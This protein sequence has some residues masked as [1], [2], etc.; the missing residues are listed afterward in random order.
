MMHDLPVEEVFARLQTSLHG[1]SEEEARRR[2]TETGPNAL[3]EE[4]PPH[5]VLIF[6]KQFTDVMILILMAAAVIAWVTGDLTD[7]LVILA[8]VV[9]N[10]IL[11]FTQEYRAERAL[12]AL[13][14][15]EIP[16]VL[17]TRDGHR[18]EIPAPELVPGDLVHLSPGVRVP[19][20]ARLVAAVHLQADESPL[21][22]ESVPVAKIREPIPSGA[23]LMERRN[24]LYMGTT[25]LAGRGDAVVAATGMETELGRIAHL[26]QTTVKGETPLQ[27]RLATLGKWLAAA[28]LAICAVIF[29]AGISRGEPVSLMLLTAVSLAVAAIPEGL[30]AVVAIVLALGA[31]RMAARHALIRK[32]PAVETLGCVTVI[33]SDK[34]GTL[35]E[36]RMSVVR[37]ALPDAAS[38]RWIEVSDRAPGEPFREDG[39]GV[40]VRRDP[41]LL[42]LLEGAA[43]CNDAQLSASFVSGKGGGDTVSP[44]PLGGEGRGEG[45]IDQV[46]GD[47]MEGALLAAAA[48]A[49]MERSALDAAYPRIAEIPF[50]TARKRM[51]TLHRT[52]SGFRFYIKGGI[53]EILHRSSFIQTGETKVPLTEAARKGILEANARMAREGLR[54][55]AAASRDLDREPASL[56]SA[57]RDLVF[58][59]LIG[60]MDPPRPEAREAVRTCREAGILPVM[61]TGDHPLTAEAIARSLGILGEG[62]RVAAGNGIAGLEEGVLK[63]GGGE[64]AVFARV[65]PDQKVRI[66][67][68]FQ[69]RGEIVAM[70]GDGVNDAPALK[71][72]HIGVAMGITGTDVSKEAADVVLLDDNFATIVSAVEEGRRIYDNIRKFTR[73][74][75]STNSGELLV[76]FLALLFGMPLPLLPVQILWINLVT[77]GLP[78]LALGAEPAEREIMKRPPRHPRESL[79]AR[80]LGWHILWVGVLMAGGTLWVFD[81]ALARYPLATAQSLVFFTLVMFQLF[82][83]MAI[84]SERDSLFAQGVGSNPYLLGAVTLGILLQVALMELPVL[85]GI[86]HTVSVSL[87]DLLLCTGVAATVFFAVELE[88]TLVRR[89]WLWTVGP[90]PA[91]P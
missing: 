19:A 28:A 50:D 56:E 49:G 68:G 60:I 17:V 52:A 46:V 15:L 79:F 4:R 86:F 37:L 88:K 54:I 58:L 21:T 8:I 24:M 64:I 84:R 67:E 27:R 83:V 16:R 57:E 3:R 25:V 26:L 36:N 62:G 23:S 61:I 77:D 40:D 22:G 87:R 66:V 7:T 29:F 53:E 32:L 18:R 59:G 35:T 43:L 39:K 63:G 47:P 13:R 2:L 9:L 72:A 48:N 89:G 78:A 1:L 71:K 91:R 73:Y 38:G 12:A 75:L 6:L 42:R 10:G 33:C 31:Q 76:M 65:L 20:D 34:T 74:M 82:H 80:G 81:W 85:Q 11:G 14:R 70:T 90:E 30:P 55:L 5:P 41:S 51:S 69:E 45:R 44:S